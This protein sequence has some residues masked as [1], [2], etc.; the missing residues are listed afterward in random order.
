MKK[1]SIIASAAVISL[2]ALLSACDRP[3]G[4]TEL[5]L[6]QASANFEI[7]R[8]VV[9][10][11]DITGDYIL[12]VEGLCSLSDFNSKSRLTVTCKDGPTSLKKHSLG[13]SNNVT[14]FAEQI[15]ATNFSPFHYR[16]VSRLQ[17]TL[18]DIDFQDNLSEYLGGSKNNND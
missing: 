12:I 10:Y 3:V 5:K 17:G 7:M 1:F 8:R 4:V 9:F 14:F 16:I 15:E 11:N 13:L 2:A 18:P 6:S